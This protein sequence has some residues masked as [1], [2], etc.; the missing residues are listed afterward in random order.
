MSLL[1]APVLA[2][3]EPSTTSKDAEAAQE[4]AATWSDAL[5]SGKVHVVASLSDV[6]F[7]WDGKDRFG[8]LADLKLA[9][10]QVVR[11]KGRREVRHTAVRLPS[12][13]ELAKLE[14]PADSITVIVWYDDE[15]VTVFVA[16]GEVYKVVGFSD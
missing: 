16:P 9:L 13:A 3:G 2:Q 1:C 4:I 10:A 7:D 6:P 15:P 8:E 5:I 11:T 12:E 14:P